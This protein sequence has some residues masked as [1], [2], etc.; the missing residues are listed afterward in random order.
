MKRT[1][2]N[3]SKRKPAQPSR[4]NRWL[5]SRAIRRSADPVRLDHQR[6]RL[7]R[8][9]L[10]AGR[11][12]RVEY[13]H[14]LDDPASVLTAQCLGA[15]AAC[16]DIDLL[17]HLVP[18]ADGQSAQAATVGLHVLHD[19]EQVAGY[20][21]LGFP[22]VAVT[23]AAEQ[24]ERAARILA[25]SRRDDLPELAARVGKLLWAGDTARLAL[26][27]RQLDVA[28]AE[29]TRL[30]LARGERRHQELGLEGGATFWYAGEYYPGV[31]RLYH[32]ENRLTALGARRRPG[33]KLVAARPVVRSGRLP[34]DSGLLLEMFVA[35]DSP[36]CSIIYDRVVRL[37]REANI[38][39][40]VRPVEPGFSLSRPGLA[41]GSSYALFDTVREA[42]AMGLD[43]GRNACDPRGK[44]VR[45]ACALLS[46]AHDRGR[47]REFVGEFLRA[48]YSRGIDASHDEGLR[49]I[50]KT[51]GLSWEE[52]RDAL[53]GN[54][55]QNELQR[56]GE[57]VLDMAP[58]RLPAFRL[59]RDDGTVELATCG[60][61][62]LWLVARYIDA[63]CPVL[64]VDVE[65]L[66][67]EEQPI[68][69]D[70][71]N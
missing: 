70:K 42:R 55:W 34:V 52:G 71:A 44:A 18:P 40:S 67:L 19:C 41:N 39:L 7:E 20:Y 3:S 35:L 64:P 17:V 51:A 1:S 10:R 65:T 27:A 28:S 24:V 25:G 30:A 59:L 9:R 26:L 36:E 54:G 31:D 14:R 43:W 45:R 37:A 16:Y 15:L 23:P 58:T 68:Y 12:H 32:L 49:E 69:Y 33:R 22:T 2:D 62:R 4:L 46:W 38:K 61:D 11:P 63:H 47:M 21:G 5:V 48:T 56:N 13:F 29:A 60:H 66:Q 8:E 50:V 53:R 6:E 57:A